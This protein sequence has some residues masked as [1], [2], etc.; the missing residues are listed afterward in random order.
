ATAS[1]DLE[2]DGF[3]QRV[4]REDFAKATVICIAHRL[5]TLIDYDKILVLDQGRLVEF[6]SPHTLL[7]LPNSAF[8]SLVDE[9][10]EANAKLLRNL[11]ETAAGVA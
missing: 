7:S 6:D 5:N 11:A 1:V 3:I 10:G 8:S 9:T 2:T 4:I